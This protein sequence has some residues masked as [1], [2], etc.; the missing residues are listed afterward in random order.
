MEFPM[1]KTLGVI[2]MLLTAIG[3][4]AVSAGNIATSIRIR[5]GEHFECRV[6][7][8]AADFLDLASIRLTESLNPNGR[9]RRFNVSWVGL[10]LG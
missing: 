10:C 4:M 8:H 1:I 5:G 3:C 6:F 2:A 7:D 9:S